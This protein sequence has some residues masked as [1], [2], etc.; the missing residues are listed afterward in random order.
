MIK[1]FDALI[2][3]ARSPKDRAAR[4]LALMCLEAALEAAD[5]RKIMKS[6]LKMSDSRL[7]VRDRVYD[8][9]KYHRIFVLGGGKAAGSMA[10]FLEQLLGNRITD[11]Y[12]NVLRGTRTRYPTKRIKLNEASH[13]IPDEAGR[14]GVGRMLKMLRSVKDED[15]IICLLSGGASAL[16]PYPIPQVSLRDKQLTTQ[17]MLR[18]GSTINE[19]NCVR[20]HLSLIKGGGLARAAFPARVLTLILS[21][22]VG[23]PLDMIASGP[24]S[25]DPTT[26]ASAISILNDRKVWRKVPRSV[27]EVLREGVAGKIVETPKEGDEVFRNVSNV[28][29][30]NNRT[31]CRGAQEYARK[32]GASSIILTSQ[33][34]GEAKDVGTV[35]SAI[36]R[37]LPMNRGGMRNNIVMVMGGETTVTVTGNGRGGRNQEMMLSASLKLRNCDGISIASI[38]TDGLDG[39]TPAAGAIIDSSTFSRAEEINLKPVQLLHNNDS[40]RFFSRLDDRIITGPTGTNLNDITIA[41]VVW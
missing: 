32:M 24:T 14:R 5:P 34:E 16:M 20:K 23:D 39:N 28:I 9:S 36:A 17:I 41:A 21:D 27:R 22:V 25:S 8:L 19:L 12:V 2:A 29:I 18:S 6:I 37:E 13:P 11:G 7:Q 33:L 26:F 10:L 35:V 30:G 1:N 4:R 3:N 15:L 38:G 31:V 40:N